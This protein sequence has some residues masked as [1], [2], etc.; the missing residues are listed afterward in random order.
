MLYQAKWYV[1]SM[2]AVIAKEPHK[3]L[4]WINSAAEEKVDIN[5]QFS[6]G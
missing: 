2:N 1:I 5:G 6:V 4:Q 3:Y